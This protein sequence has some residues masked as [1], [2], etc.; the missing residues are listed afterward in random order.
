MSVATFPKIIR[1]KG[2]DDCPGGSC[3]HCGATGRWIVRFVD[4]TGQHRGAMRGCIKL[5]PVSAI[6]LEELRLTDK[7]AKYAKQGWTLNRADQGAV[8]AIEAFYAGA[9]TEVQAMSV[10]R[11]AKARNVARF[12][13]R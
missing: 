5:F 7:A 12:R 4:E 2:T 13:G 8:N 11:G 9:L 6:A 10:V 3:P 1:F